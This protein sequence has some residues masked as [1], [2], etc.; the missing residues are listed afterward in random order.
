MFQ[1]QE[2]VI[3]SDK[4]YQHSAQ[5]ERIPCPRPGC[6]D[7]LATASNLVYHLHIHDIEDKYVTYLMFSVDVL[8]NESFN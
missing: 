5:D 8:T 4:F 6:T 2:A 7:S 3:T 1:F